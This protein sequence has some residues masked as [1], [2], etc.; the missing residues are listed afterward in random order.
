MQRNCAAPPSHLSHVVNL[1]L[2]PVCHATDANSFD[3]DAPQDND[4]MGKCIVIE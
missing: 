2:D 4:K 1:E 3:V